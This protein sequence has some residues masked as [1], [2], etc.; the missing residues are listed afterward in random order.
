MTGEPQESTKRIGLV[1]KI[2]H[3]GAIAFIG[4]LILCAKIVVFATDNGNV[5]FSLDFPGSDPERYSISVQ[6][7]GSA[8]YECTGKL[9]NDSDDTENYQ[10]TFKFSDANRND[11]C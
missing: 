1:R 4:L 2:A 7:D 11:I 3:D 6:S 10:S 8:T 5:K 9:S